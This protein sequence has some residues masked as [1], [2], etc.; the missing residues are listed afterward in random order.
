MS[1]AKMNAKTSKT[2]VFAADSSEHSQNA[3]S[4]MMRYVIRPED[5]LHVV[6]CVPEV[7][8]IIKL[9]T[10]EFQLRF[11]EKQKLCSELAGIASAQHISFTNSEVVVGDP[12]QELVESVKKHRA[13]M[14]VMG[15]R[16]MGTV[17]GALMGSVSSHCVNQAPCAVVVVKNLQEG[18]Y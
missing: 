16:G 2:V 11:A 4:Y 3:F 9:Q 7:R 14:L 17:K 1:N 5:K 6:T 13:D 12:R 8:G 10:A 15:S 18:M